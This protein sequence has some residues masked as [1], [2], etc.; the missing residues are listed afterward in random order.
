[1]PQVD[2][3]TYKDLASISLAPDETLGANIALARKRLRWSQ[4]R[5]ADEMNNLVGGGWYQTTVSRVEQGTQALN[6]EQL[7][8]L[9][10]VLG[11]QILEGTQAQAELV[12]SRDLLKGTARAIAP[13][14]G[15]KL[16]QTGFF[17]T[18][19]QVSERAKT[20]HA[21]T[22]LTRS[23]D[24]AQKLASPTPSV[25][26]LQ[27]AKTSLQTALDSV[28]WLLKVVGGQSK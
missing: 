25:D 6:Y 19:K 22:A 10:E 26:E 4:K 18:L 7:Q 21:T 2:D 1:M 28:E 11:G 12:K 5:L 8:R 20:M 9:T 15:E 14:L 27:A 17:D 3:Q 16:S 24:A 13:L 23:L